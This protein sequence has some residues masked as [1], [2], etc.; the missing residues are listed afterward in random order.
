MIEE[1]VNVLVYDIGGL[2]AQSTLGETVH[3]FI[4]DSVKILLLLYFM[5]AFIGVFR[6]FISPSRIRDWMTTQTHGLSYV[7]A[8]LLGILTPFCSCSSIP[9]FM[10][11]IK[12]GVPLGPS[13]SF[14]VTSPL[15]NEYLVVLM[16]GFFGLR[17]T[18]M[19]ILFGMVLGVSAGMLAGRLN[20]EKYIVEDIR[21]D[22]DLDEKKYQGVGERISYGM[23]EASSIVRKLWM[24]VLLGV[25]VGAVIHGYVPEE[26]IHN[27]LERTGVF[28]VP[29]ATVVGVP[30]YANCSAVVPVAVVL[31]QKGVPLGTALAFMMATAALSLPEAVILRRV[32]KLPLIAVFFTMVAAGIMLIGYLFNFIQ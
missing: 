28:S 19:Y 26:M 3:F 29:F 1:A 7:A 5:I 21:G 9:I 11:F 27:V 30:I 20:L 2:E 12:A 13:F 23:E 22:R 17:I 8:S 18:G 24:W 4:Y 6:T 25:G 10:S 32:M 14:L 16:V 15:I 31:F